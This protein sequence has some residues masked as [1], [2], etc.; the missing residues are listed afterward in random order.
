MFWMILHPLVIAMAK[1]GT[2][3]LSLQNLPP[4]TL[5][6]EEAILFAAG[7]FLCSVVGKIISSRCITGLKRR[8][9]EVG[10]PDHATK[11]RWVQECAVRL[12]KLRNGRYSV[13]LLLPFSFSFIFI[14][15][16]LLYKQYPS[17]SMLP[18]I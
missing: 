18:D 3:H 14:R 9:G 17:P 8:A 16:D 4:D 15:T 7:V 12:K 1:M 13:G 6:I 11:E 5:R 10:G 2:E